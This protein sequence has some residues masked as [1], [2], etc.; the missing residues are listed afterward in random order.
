MS[1]VK[2]T[3]DYSDP[4]FVEIDA[5]YQ[6]RMIGRVEFEIQP[7]KVLE[8]YWTFVEPEFRGCGLGRKMYEY[9]RGLGYKIRQSNALTA[10]GRQFW[11]KNPEMALETINPDIKNPEF[12][13]QQEIGDFILTAKTHKGPYMSRLDIRCYDKDFKLLG[14]ADFWINPRHL[15]SGLTWVIPELRKSGVASTMYAYAKMLGNDILPSSTQLPPGKAMWGAWKK[16][17]DAKHLVAES[18]SYQ[19]PTI[20]KGDKLLVGKFK[21][22]KAEVKGFSKDDNNQPVLKTTKGDQKLFKPRLVKL[23]KESMLD[24][25]NMDNDKGIGATP[26]N[27]NIDYFGLRVQMT[28]LTFLRMA[29]E[30]TVD[31]DTEKRILSMAEYIKGG[32]PVG[33]PFLMIEIPEGWEQGD[34]SENA[35]ISGHEGR[36]RMEAVIKAEG[37]TPVEVHLVFPG[38]RRRHITD[39]MISTMNHSIFTERGNFI[40]GPW[41]KQ[42]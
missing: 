22:S 7:D 20:N 34:M 11:E 27:R 24:E 33:S 3:A 35:R 6:D 14:S 41:F 36:H 8:S 2:I 1:Q 42:I 10:K 30:L 13:D 5:F 4:E 38:L 17:G 26:N 37:N 15:T 28:P 16:S 31:P 23:M 29:R 9:A 25:L 12:K 21:N 18:E 19:P 40:L 39:E 32:G